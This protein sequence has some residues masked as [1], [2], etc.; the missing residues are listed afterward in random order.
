MNNKCLLPYTSNK[1][2]QLDS[3]D[4]TQLFDQKN[5]EQDIL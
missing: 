4:L 1:V 5:E 2:E 3:L